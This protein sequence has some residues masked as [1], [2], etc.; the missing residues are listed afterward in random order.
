VTG[1][2]LVHGIVDDFGK[3]VMQRLFI[4]ATDVHP[5]PP[6]NGLQSLKHLDMLGGVSGF[7][8]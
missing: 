4:G 3:Q 7:P 1:Q 6:A 5:G 2:C 8:A